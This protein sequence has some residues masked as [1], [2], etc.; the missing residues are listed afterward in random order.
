MWVG[1]VGR[2][3]LASAMRV[4]MLVCPSMSISRWV[5]MVA[6]GGHCSVVMWHIGAMMGPLSHWHVHRRSGGLWASGWGSVLG[7]FFRKCLELGE[8]DHRR[9]GRSN[10]RSLGLRSR[11]QQGS[12]GLFFPILKCLT[13]HCVGLKCSLG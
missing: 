7:A 13:P 9:R 8:G 1:E 12:L 4:G 3:A 2:M 11:M 6:V 5:M 10:S